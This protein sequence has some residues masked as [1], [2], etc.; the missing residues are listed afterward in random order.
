MDLS[1]PY[2]WATEKSSI[3]MRPTSF[4]KL[5]SNI[6]LSRSLV[7][8]T[9]SVDLVRPLRTR[10]YHMQ[11]SICKPP[12]QCSTTSH[13][14]QLHKERTKDCPVTMGLWPGWCSGSIPGIASSGN[15]TIT[16][17][18]S[19]E[20]QVRVLHLATYFFYPSYCMSASICFFIYFW[21]TFIVL[22]FLSVFLS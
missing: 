3:Q 9:V 13:K 20:A 16:S 11:A 7:G 17:V 22:E 2:F 4:T 10:P 14:R 8:L 18:T 12:T 1:G 19:S 21:F 6:G 5:V 15:I